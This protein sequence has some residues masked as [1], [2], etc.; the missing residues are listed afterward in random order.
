MTIQ[1]KTT[2]VRAA[3]FR[4]PADVIL[5]GRELPAPGPEEVIVEVDACGICGTDLTAIFE[6]RAEYE[7][8]GHEVAGR[9]V[10]TGSKFDSIPLNTRVVLESSSAC[11]VCAHCRNMQQELCSNVTSFW[12]KGYFGFAERMPSPGISA[13]PYDGLSPGVAS[14]SEPLGVALDMHRLTDIRQDSVVLVSGLGPIGLMAVRLAKLSGARRI[15]AVSYSRLKVRNETALKFGAD[16]LILEDKTP[17][18]TFRFPE[19]PDRFLVTA[20]PQVLPSMFQ[21]AAK[22]S[23]LSY[24]GIKNG[25]GAKISFDANEF[26]FKKLQLRASFASP[27][28]LTPLALTL[29]KDGAVD[30]EALITHRFGLEEMPEAV[31]VACFEKETC[32]KVVMV[33]R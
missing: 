12:P 26:H 31:R 18:A 2:S 15:Y 20:P 32:I 28:M 7:N 13:V 19:K 30:G 4:S 10:E 17:V 14:L 1:L 9:I 33:R 21:I 25:E 29:L 24:I 3:L 16:E 27:A 23:I 22:G 11:G 6:G 5:R 8:F